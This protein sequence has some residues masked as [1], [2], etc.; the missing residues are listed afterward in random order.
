MQAVWTKHAKNKEE[1]EK[2]VADF[3]S[4]RNAFDS[5]SEVIKENMKKKENVRD[6]DNPGW[7][8][9]QIAVN[10]YNAAID[11]VLKLIKP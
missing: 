8:E 5:L 1:K 11:D 2:A 9:R 7:K 6:Y 3:N 4:Y 10:E